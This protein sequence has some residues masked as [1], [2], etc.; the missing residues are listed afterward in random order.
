[1]I[2]LTL[3]PL[4]ATSSLLLFPLSPLFFPVALSPFPI[5][6]GHEKRCAS[7]GVSQRVPRRRMDSFI[8]NYEKNLSLI[9][10]PGNGVF[11]KAG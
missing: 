3:P 8:H 5:G 1:M 11:V 10:R 9:F 7:C 6:V 2:T 4:S